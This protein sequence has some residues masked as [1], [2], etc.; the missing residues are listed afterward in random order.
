MVIDQSPVRHVTS[1]CCLV[2]FLKRCS[3]VS[4]VFNSQYFSAARNSIHT[5]FTVFLAQVSPDEKCDIMSF[6]VGL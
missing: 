4:A 3:G 6:T 2:E 5:I 1:C